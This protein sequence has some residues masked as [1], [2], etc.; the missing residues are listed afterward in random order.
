MLDR[1]YP[2]PSL[3]RDAADEKQRHRSG[4]GAIRWWAMSTMSTIRR[5][6]FTFWAVSDL[7]GEELGQFVGKISSA[8]RP[9]GASS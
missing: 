4:P 1:P 9:K 8:L 3:L 5:G 2:G 6:A 7:D